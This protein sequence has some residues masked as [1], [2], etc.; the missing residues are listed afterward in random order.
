MSEATKPVG[1]YG[2]IDWADLTNNWFAAD[3][4]WIQSRSVVRV[5][6]SV[7]TEGE[8][9]PANNAVGRVFFSNSLQSLLINVTG[10]YH[11]VA[12]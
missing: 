6:D 1:G 2:D 9:P 4:E 10:G 7:P 8:V 3:A 5:A 11:R 12:S